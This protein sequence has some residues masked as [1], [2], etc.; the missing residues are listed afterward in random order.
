MSKLIS[1]S[2]AST[3]CIPGQ[4]LC[5]SGPKCLESDGTYLF[6]GFIYSSVAGKVTTV[7][8]EDLTLVKV[9]WVCSTGVGCVARVSGV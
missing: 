9:C 6:N 8:H 4:R 7:Q 2:A 1:N 3:M 5:P